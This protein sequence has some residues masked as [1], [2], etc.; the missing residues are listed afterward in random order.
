VTPILTRESLRFGPGVQERRTATVTVTLWLSGTVE[1]EYK[2]YR[3]IQCTCLLLG[4][5][6]RGVEEGGVQTGER[7]KNGPGLAG[8]LGLRCHAVGNKSSYR[9]RLVTCSLDE[10][11]ISTAGT[12]HETLKHPGL[13]IEPFQPR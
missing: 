2:L 10:S 6:D 7:E 12:R 4:H 3:L 11:D 5:Q 8:H 1:T 9:V 13:K